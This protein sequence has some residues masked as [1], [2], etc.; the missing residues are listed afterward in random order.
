[1]VTERHTLSSLVILLLLTSC[2][3]VIHVDLNSSDPE[4]VV[5]AKFF[6]DS[7]SLVRLTSTTSY[8]S[9]GKPGIIE[10]ATVILSD[11]IA[12]EILNYT[13]NGCYTGSSVIGTEDTE[14]KL[15][16]RHDGISYQGSSYMPVKA[17]LV[18]VD[19]TM[20]DE[21]GVLNPYGETISTITCEFSD[22]PG[23]DNYYMIRFM[24]NNE[25]LER[26]YLLTEST[27]NSG[28]INNAN[29]TI[30]FWESIF[31]DGGEVDVQLY[32]ID[33]SVYKY[34][35]QLSDVLFWKGRVIPPNPYNPTSNIDN[36]ALGY[37]A[38]WSFDSRRIILE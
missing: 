19:Y 15:E 16:I 29:D 13:G 5:E 28:Y 12:S 26:Y 20:T 33:E 30:T 18:S 24:S 4:F 1:M 27:A 7:V 31:F 23:K 2:E 34:F 37:F 17:D 36:G 25:L 14:Y 32:S 9:P 10:D 11:G 21:P 35:L 38:A 3:E 6:K 8:F 22:N